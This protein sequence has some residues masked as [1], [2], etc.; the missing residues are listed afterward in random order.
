LFKHNFA[1]NVSEDQMKYLFMF[2]P[3][4]MHCF[5]RFE[6]VT[7]IPIIQNIIVQVSTRGQYIIYFYFSE[8]HLKRQEFWLCFQISNIAIDNSQFELIFFFMLHA[9]IWI[10]T[11]LM[12]LWTCLFGI[13]TI[14]C[15]EYLSQWWI[16]A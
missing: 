2:A 5:N 14:C 8:S 10:I 3:P 16:I 4:L 13:K 9:E 1:T 15:T 11:I 6:K 12:G 7:T